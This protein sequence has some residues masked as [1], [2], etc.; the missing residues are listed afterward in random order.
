MA[1]K[2]AGISKE[3]YGGFVLDGAKLR[4]IADVLS[5]YG[6]R[7]SPPVN[8][9]YEVHRKDDSFYSTNDINTVLSDDNSNSKAINRLYLRLVREQ[10]QQIDTALGSTKGVA[11]ICFGENESL[12]KFS[13]QPEIWFQIVEAD[14]DWCFLLADE[15]DAQIKR[16][17]YKRAFRLPHRLLDFFAPVMLFAAAPLWMLGRSTAPIPALSLND[18]K[19]MSTDEKLQTIFMLE[20]QNTTLNTRA[21]VWGT[22]AIFAVLFLMLLAIE[23]RPVTRFLN[24]LNQPVFYWGDMISRYDRQQKLSSNIKWVVIIGFGISLLAS[25]AYSW[26]RTR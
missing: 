19:V 12:R 23:Y 9:T 5:T 13:A 25:F 21:Y 20:V 16:I 15:V 2:Q 7:L 4:K 22:L 10:S 3:Y 14:R 8:V 26:L 6:Q 11:R 17:R 1:T 24:L 18:V